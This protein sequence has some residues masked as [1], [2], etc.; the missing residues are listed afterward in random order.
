[1]A[2]GVQFNKGILEST[3]TSATWKIPTSEVHCVSINEL[4]YLREARHF[5]APLKD[6]EHIDN[7]LQF[8]WDLP[9]GYKTIESVSKE[10][11]WYK[12]KTAKNFLEVAKFFEE[13]TD[14]KTVYKIKNFY[15]DKFY[16]VKV[17]FYTNPIH[18]PHQTNNHDNLDRIKKILV[19]I[20]TNISEK[21]LDTYEEKDVKSKDDISTRTS[22]INK[23]FQAKTIEQ[24]IQM[25]D[26]E[27]D[28]FL[29]LQDQRQMNDDVKQRKKQNKSL[30]VFSGIIVAALCVWYFNSNSGEDGRINELE[31]E[32]KSTQEE[33]EEM[34]DK[35][36]SQLDS[37]D[38]YFDGDIEKALEVANGIDDNSTELNSSFYTEILVRN[39]EIKEALERFPDKAHLIAEHTVRYKEKDDVLEMEFD[40]PYFKFEQAVLKEDDEAIA[41]IIPD[42]KSPT[43]RQKELIFNY[44]LRTDTDEAL[45]YAETN[46]NVAW[47]IKVLESKKKSLEAKKDKLDKDD[48]KD[49]IKEV[50]DDIEEVSRKIESLS[51]ET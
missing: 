22:I 37:Y 36:E 33:F 2:K 40:E 49:E 1:M 43:D 35:Y 23:I 42:L 34:S 31:A 30:I 7:Q 26:V 44:Y 41:D 47:E 19:R 8:T 17:L 10:S 46:K 3:R 5:A 50:K 39:G 20:L 6:I 24:L 21:K 51:E 11:T 29:S 16:N 25:V 32:A 45:T 4:G 12:L 13:N 28:H 27:Y 9:E 48:D 38:A 14:L 18:L 15:V